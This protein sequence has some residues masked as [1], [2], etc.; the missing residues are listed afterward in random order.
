MYGLGIK[1]QGVEFKVS[2]LGYKV[3]GFRFRVSVWDSGVA[4]RVW[5]SGLGFNA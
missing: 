3:Q 2:G 4:S 5:G 1:V